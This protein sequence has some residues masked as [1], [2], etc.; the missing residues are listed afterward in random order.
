MNPQV[1]KIGDKS[2]LKFLSEEGHQVLLEISSIRAII[3]AKTT[4]QAFC[5][6]YTADDKKV[7]DAYTEFSRLI[8]VLTTNERG[9]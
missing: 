4:G 6:I 5:K 8:E 1:I 7:Y 2:Y 3:S 9:V